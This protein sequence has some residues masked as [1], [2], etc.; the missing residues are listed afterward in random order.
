MGA[1]PIPTAFGLSSSYARF[2]P[3]RYR[4]RTPHA[5]QQ[6]LLDRGWRRSG[7]Y[8]YKPNLATSCCPQYTISLDISKFKFSKSYKQVVLRFD[9]YV[10]G[11]SDNQNDQKTSF[12]ARH[13]LPSSANGQMADT[14][15]EACSV[16]SADGRSWQ[17]LTEAQLSSKG[18]VRK[19]ELG[20]SKKGYSLKKPKPFS[21][22]PMASEA[23]EDV[24][25][26]LRRM[27][28]LV[29]A[30]DCGTSEYSHRFRTELVRSEFDPETFALYCKYQI[31]VHKDTPGELSKKRYC[32]FLVDS[33]LVPEPPFTPDRKVGL[34]SYHHRYYLDDRLIACGMLDILPR[35]VSSVY[36]IY[37]PDLATLALGKYSVIR[38]ITLAAKFGRYMPDLQKYYMGMRMKY[39]AINNEPSD[40]LDPVR[41]LGTFLPLLRNWRT[42]PA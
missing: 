20:T 4:L 1:R 34:G 29:Y 31:A 17:G 19:T 16:T 28:E 8:L 23:A 3:S 2:G 12:D 25:P 10:A 32:N 9:R 30:A 39:K 7:Q 41:K 14:G 35:C 18:N 36:F 5:P 24:P 37:D 21:V 40:L 13:A 15:A 26:A 33:P 11:E 42:R 27:V 6:R 22:P 38:E